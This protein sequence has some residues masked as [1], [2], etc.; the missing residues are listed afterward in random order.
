MWLS[1]F[2]LVMALLAGAGSAFPSD[3][4]ISCNLTCCQRSISQEIWPQAKVRYAD[5]LSSALKQDT[6]GVWDSEADGLLSDAWSCFE[7]HAVPLE[8]AALKSNC[9]SWSGLVLT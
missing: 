5:T 1:L 7:T 9:P 3:M 6:S 2:G 4:Q 8:T